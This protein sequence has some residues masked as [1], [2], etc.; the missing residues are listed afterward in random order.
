[1]SLDETTK[2][3]VSRWIRAVIHMSL[4]TPGTTE[5]LVPQLLQMLRNNKVGPIETQ[6]IARTLW[7]KGIDHQE[8]RDGG[9]LIVESATSQIVISGANTLSR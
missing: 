4:S 8:Y 2:P 7:N 6:W 1:M 9:I 5:G 3:I